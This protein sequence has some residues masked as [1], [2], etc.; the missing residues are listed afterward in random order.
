MPPIGLTAF[1]FRRQTSTAKTSFHDIIIS[2]EFY[3]PGK[4]FF[5]MKSTDW[6]K[7]REEY[8]SDSLTPGELSVKYSV[9]I[10]KLREK[11]ET[12]EWLRNSEASPEERELRTRRILALSDLLLDKVR[13]ALRELGKYE[14]KTKER[15]KEVQYDDELK[16]PISEIN[17]ESEKI[18]ITNSLIDTSA[19]KQLVSTLKDIKDIQLGISDSANSENGESGVILISEVSLDESGERI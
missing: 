11:I 16:K 18:E 3:S 9:S 1:R 13:L 17:T 10:A 4:E 7:I 5:I 12:E 19:L 2:G 15:T 8:E 14:L 6:K